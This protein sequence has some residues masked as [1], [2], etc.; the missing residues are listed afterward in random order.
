LWLLL[1]QLYSRLG[2]SGR[3]R[4]AYSA[5]L[6]ACPAS[7]ALWRG[8]ARLEE[9]TA[10]GIGIAKARTLLEAGRQRNPKN[11]ELWLEASRLE[12]RAGNAKLADTVLSRGLQECPSSGKL[13]AEDIDTAPRHARKRKSLDALK[14]ADMD[15][16]PFVVL[17]VARLFWAERKVDK[18]R[19]WFSRAVALDK[20]LGDAWVWALA[21]EAGTGSKE[22]VAELTAACVAAEPR[23]GDRW[24]AVSKAPESARL[25][26]AAILGQAVEQLGRDMAAAREG[27]GGG[28]AVGAIALSAGGAAAQI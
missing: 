18:A 25:S 1:G 17:A 12:R 20:D 23:H 21:H 9:G 8:A 6:R 27:G 28:D 7:I 11:A 22:A 13:I 26:A 15:S 19:K 16:D 24:T 10:G 3:A 2:D 14:S 4:E 5:G